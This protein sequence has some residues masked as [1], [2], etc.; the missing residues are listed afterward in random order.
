V[1]AIGGKIVGDWY[2]LYNTMTVKGSAAPAV[3]AAGESVTYFDSTS[4]TIKASEHGAAFSNVALSGKNNNFA[5]SQTMA[6]LLS[7]GTAT[8]SDGA[9]TGDGTITSV[10]NKDVTIPASGTGTLAV[11]R[12]TTLPHSAAQGNELIAEANHADTAVLDLARLTDSADTGAA[13]LAGGAGDPAYGPLNLAG[14]ATIIAGLLPMVSGGTGT[15]LTGTQYGLPYFATTATLG[16]TAAGT[17]TTLLHGNA[18]GIPTWGAV[19]LTA[20]VSGTLP[21]GSGGTGAGTFTSNNLLKG[22]ATGAIAEAA[23]AETAAGVLQTPLGTSLQLVGKARLTDAAVDEIVVKGGN[24]YSQAVTNKTGGNLR[25]IGGVAVTGITVND[26]TALAGDSVTVTVNGVITVKWNPGDW[27]AETSNAVTATNIATAFAGTTNLTAVAVGATVYFS[28]ANDTVQAI[29]SNGSD[30]VNMSLVGNRGGLVYAGTSYANLGGG[31]LAVDG[32]LGGELW[33]LNQS[34]TKQYN[35]FH[36]N[37]NGGELECNYQND[38]LMTGV[39]TVWKINKSAQFFLTSLASY[40]SNAVLV[41]DPGNAT[42]GLVASGSLKHATSGSNNALAMMGDGSTDYY[43]TQGSGGSQLTMS[44]SVLQVRG[45]TNNAATVFISGGAS[46]VPTLRFE[47]PT[48]TQQNRLWQVLAS[49]DTFVCQNASE[50]NG[51]LMSTPW[52][53]S[54]AGLFGVGAWTNPTNLWGTGI[55][56][57]S[58]SGGEAT[59][60]LAGADHTAIYTY[61]YGTGDARLKVTSEAG[62]PV[63]IGNSAIA[64]HLTNGAGDAGVARNTTGVVEINNGTNGTLATLIQDTSK[65]QTAN[66]ASMNMKSTSSNVTLSTVSTTTTVASFIPA[67]AYIVGVVARVT[68]II[69]TAT[70]VDVGVLADTARF[71][72]DM[73]VAAGQTGSSYKLTVPLAPYMSAAATNL[74]ITVDAQNTTTGKVRLTLFYF[75][76]TEPGS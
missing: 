45:N 46:N 16:T 10:A 23:V 14:G 1:R 22:N 11:A 69:D 33:L 56:L 55:V 9:G 75:D 7:N 40:P 13:L 57:K 59:S 37:Y 62:N 34:Q 15:N 36:N 20:D 4:N 25:L 74:L 30:L 63:S 68:E 35:F 31:G 3:S 61:D 32:K 5:A 2:V 49:A 51:A 73:G 65:I 38:D 39:Q 12:L 71:V 76:L 8:F 64:F 58:L 44:G 17:G 54:N 29:Q 67:D 48:A 50:R 6:G 41:V 18:T 28:P 19:S 42:P 66:T 52:K 24:A 21:V 47:D 53:V 26:Y 60:C 43:K 72:D 27:A 70:K